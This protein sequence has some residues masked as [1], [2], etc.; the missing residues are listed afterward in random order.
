MSRIDD[1]RPRPPA[2]RVDVNCDRVQTSERAHRAGASVRFAGA[3][4]ASR[5]HD[6]DELGKCRACK[7]RKPERGGWDRACE[8][9]QRVFMGDAEA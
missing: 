8:H 1:K 6:I 3:N 2:D 9:D 7:E 5:G 4:T